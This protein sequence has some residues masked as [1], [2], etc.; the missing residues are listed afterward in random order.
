MSFESLTHTPAFELPEYVP[1]YTE[2]LRG[3]IEECHEGLHRVVVNKMV[4]RGKYE[5]IA[6]ITCQ[7]NG[8][9]KSHPAA[10][11]D[12][13]AEYAMSCIQ[14][15][16]EKSDFPGTY[17]VTLF[18]APGKGRFERSKHIDM[19]DG[20]NAKDVKLISEEDLLEQMRGYVGELHEAMVSKDE[21]VTA[22]FKQ[23][24][25]ENKQMLKIVG[26]SQR[27]LAE[28]E[29]L[30]AKHSLEMSM[31]KDEMKMR[32]LEE[33]MKHARWKEFKDMVEETGAPKALARVAIKKFKEMKVG[34]GADDSAALKKAEEQKK[35]AAKAQESRKKI[36]EA[37][38][39]EEPSSK[40][41]KKKK[42]KCCEAPKY[43]KLDDDRKQCK[44]CGK[45]KK[46]KKK[47][48]IKTEE[49][50]M[51]EAQKLVESSPLT[52]AASG[53]KGTV[54]ERDQWDEISKVLSEPQFEIFKKIGDSKDDNEVRK[55]LDDLMDTKNVLNNLM[56][57]GEKV[58]EEQQVFLEPL[59][60]YIA[61]KED[62]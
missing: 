60:D 27:Q 22:L 19:A 13:I 5:Q 51:E 36:R 3:L 29:A 31:H 53:L 11:A 1:Q 58:D 14:Y 6:T 28:V 26:E 39:S 61:E 9:R 18:G 40:G 16:I 10:T 50:L 21:M 20:E 17:K 52:L 46:R 38:D 7:E 37:S 59:I 47:V 62:D 23:V 15:E 30:R 32:E 35:I 49:E 34:R 33:E 43:K 54:D 55:H 24:L 2:D 42:K 25:D 45:I 44:N 57:L 4:R 48:V 12:E 41:E 8:T 56:D